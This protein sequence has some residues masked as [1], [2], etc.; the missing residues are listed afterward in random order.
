M[1]TS[2]KAASILGEGSVSVK[3]GG[4]WLVRMKGLRRDEEEEEGPGMGMPPLLV[5]AAT[6]PEPVGLGRL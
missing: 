4:R 1:S 6:G 2:G 5:E 3:E